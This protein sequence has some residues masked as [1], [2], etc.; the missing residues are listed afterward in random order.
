M[1]NGTVRRGG[2]HLCFNRSLQP[3]L[4][5]DRDREGIAQ[6]SS[7]PLRGH[8]R[9]RRHVEPKNELSDVTHV[10]VKFVP[11]VSQHPNQVSGGAIASGLGASTG[12]SSDRC[13]E[14][15][16]RTDAIKPTHPSSEASRNPSKASDASCTSCRYRRG[17]NRS[18]R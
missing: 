17:S 13:C 6:I 14:Q 3:G 4:I 7:W 9:L 2:I 18:E 5:G 8:H 10:R 15:E 11:P 16:D 12:G 1:C